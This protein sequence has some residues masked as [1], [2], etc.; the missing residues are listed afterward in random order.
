MNSRLHIL[1]TCT[2]LKTLPIPADLKLRSV[3]GATLRER[4]EKW[5]ARVQ[6]AHA[7][8]RPAIDLYSGDH[9]GIAK[10]LSDIATNRGFEPQLW[11]ISTGF[12]LIPGQCQIPAYSATFS[13]THP[14]S[15]CVSVNGSSRASSFAEWWRLLGQWA[16]PSHD[17]PRS[18]SALF[19]AEPKAT[20]MV[21]ASAAYLDA[22]RS[23]LEAAAGH[24]TSL[25]QLLVVSAG[26]KN[27]GSLTACLIPVDARL[28][29]ELG[30]ARRTLNIR[31]A[32][33]VLQGRV[34]T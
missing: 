19:A 17:S 5:I 3:R 15:V 20:F 22:I 9:W 23:D 26:T 24:L 21:I 14:D 33:R 31:V 13:S 16:G 4:C 28:Q 25:Q 29:A 2:K 32:R 18:L 34:R 7:Q 11:V 27:L 10:S 6:Q 12:G 30:G 8:R 1:V